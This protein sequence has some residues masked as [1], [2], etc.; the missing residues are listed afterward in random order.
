M[1]GDWRRSFAVA[2]IF[3]A[4]SCFNIWQTTVG[5]AQFDR[6]T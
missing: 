5:A 4:K 3:P 2:A 6:A 1:I